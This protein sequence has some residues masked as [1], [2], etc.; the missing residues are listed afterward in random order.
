L[1]PEQRPQIIPSPIDARI[2]RWYVQEGQ[3]LKKG[4]TLAFLSEIKTDYLDPDIAPRTREQ[5]VA[6]EGAIGAYRDK[7]AALE[8]QIANMEAQ[9]A[10][11]KQQVQRKM[12]QVRFKIQ[13]DSADLMQAIIQDSIAKVQYERARNLFERGIDPRSKVEDRQAKLQETRNKIV[14][15]ENKL[16]ANRTE[17]RITR[18]ELSAIQ[19]EYSE[20][21]AKARS[22]IAAAVSQQYDAESDANKLRIQTSNYAK[23]A[24]FHYIT[25]PQDCYVTKIVT[26]GIGETIKEGEG[27]VSIMPADYNLAVELYID[28]MDFPLVYDKRRNSEV[29]FIFDGWPAFIFS[30][31]PG[32]SFGTYTGEVVAIDNEISTNGQYR[33]LVAEKAGSPPWP[34]ALRVGSGAKGI[35]LLNDVPLWYELWRQLNGFPPDYYE[36]NLLPAESI[37]QKTPVQLIK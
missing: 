5:V 33:I 18:V 24:S 28:P 13:A 4:D 10:L 14:A 29:R 34:A 35:L 36:N 8:N 20:K 15:A 19:A 31:W 26:P 3:L 7:A 16:N 30:G 1:R 9:L 12:E 2:D 27:I 25:A 23:R 11:K 17:L 37:K 6:K 22:E 32:Q 21:I